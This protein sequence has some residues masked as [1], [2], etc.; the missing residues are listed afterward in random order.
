M[1][2]LDT[3]LK[4]DSLNHLFRN[5]PVCFHASMRAARAC[6]C[7]E[8]L[9]IVDTDNSAAVDVVAIG[10]RE[11]HAKRATKR[12]NSQLLYQIDPLYFDR[13]LLRKGVEYSLYTGLVCDMLPPVSLLVIATPENTTWGVISTVISWD[14][15]G[16]IEIRIRP[17]CDIQLTRMMGP[18]ARLVPITTAT[19][20]F[21]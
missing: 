6:L 12:R 2:L 13:A 10:M 1:K 16:E 17:I 4:S 20:T 11:V 8:D 15:E 7:P 21:C 18:V 5:K 14:D 3:P 9:F 19:S